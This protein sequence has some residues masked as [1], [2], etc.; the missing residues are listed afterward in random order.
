M[1][2]AYLSRYNTDVSLSDYAWIGGFTITDVGI[3]IG[4]KDQSWNVSF[5]AKNVF[6]K[7]AISYGFTSGT[8][9]S[10]PRW[11][12]VQVSAKL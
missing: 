2:T 10:T 8:L 7:I 9:E 5:L 4:A 1:N 12:G 6:N 11:Y 3:G